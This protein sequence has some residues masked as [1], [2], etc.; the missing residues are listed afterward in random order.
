MNR[1]NHLSA[2]SR[3]IL[4]RIAEGYDYRKLIS[5]HSELTYGEVFSAAEEALGLEESEADYEAR[6]ADTKQR[7][8]R[9]YEPWSE[10]DDVRLREIAAAPTLSTLDKMSR[11]MERPQ[12]QIRARLVEIGLISDRQWYLPRRPVPTRA[13]DRR[14]KRAS[15]NPFQALCELADREGNWCWNLMCTTCGHMYFDY[16]FYELS[17]GRHPVGREWRTSAN[18]P[19]DGNLG[20]VG[21]VRERIKE[22]PRLYLIFTEASA[23]EIIETCKFPDSLGYLGLALAYT[24]GLERSER[25]LSSRWGSQMLDLVGEDSPEAP[26]FR[27]IVDNPDR[28]LTW[29][30]LNWVEHA[31]PNHRQL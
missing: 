16:G 2:N 28:V 1:N 26:R 14:D 9:A 22:N 27:E 31:L 5:E 11:I 4:H 6:I 19:V 13:E 15:S 25:Q 18:R 8:P 10:E 12:S 24:E 3:L 17:L 7:F 21:D 30:D 23:K 20:T 29:Q